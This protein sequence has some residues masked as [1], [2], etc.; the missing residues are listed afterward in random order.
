MRHSWHFALN[1]VFIEGVIFVILTLTN[2]RAFD[3]V[4]PRTL[5]EAVSCRIRLFIAFIG[6]VN[7]GIINT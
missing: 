2:V 4:I 3:T 1:A 7:G 6:L 5:K